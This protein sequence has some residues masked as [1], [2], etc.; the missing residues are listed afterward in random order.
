MKIAVQKDGQISRF[1]RDSS[2]N[3]DLVHVRDMDTKEVK[4]IDKEQVIQI[5]ELVF[6]FKELIVMFIST[7][8][9]LFP[10]KAV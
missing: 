6:T 9:K 4:V 3:N 10:K 7:F 1:V 5:V 2:V 8:K